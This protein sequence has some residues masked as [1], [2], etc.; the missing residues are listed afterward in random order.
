MSLLVRIVF[1]LSFKDTQCG[2]KVFRRKA[3]LDIVDELETKGFETDVEILWRL[4]KKNYK[5]IEHPVTWM[6][7]EG[8]T[9]R[10]SQSKNMFI[11]LMKI[12][13]GL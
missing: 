9:F 1:G 10:L 11:S 7:S 6:H 3:I 8:S 12:M 4:A 2:A 13:F 5:I